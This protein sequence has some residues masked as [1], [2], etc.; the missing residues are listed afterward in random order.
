M[1]RLCRLYLDSLP[2]RK[3]YSN[4]HHQ[5][6]Q[7][8]CTQRACQKTY[9]EAPFY[10]PG[11]NQFRMSHSKFGNAHVITYNHGR[12]RNKANNS[13]PSPIS[14]RNTP[15][16]VLPIAI[17][18]AISER[19]GAYGTKRCLLTPKIHSPA[20]RAPPQSDCSPYPY[21]H[22]SPRTATVVQYRERHLPQTHCPC[23]VSA[24]FRAETSPIIRSVGSRL[25]AENNLRPIVGKLCLN[26]ILSQMI[27]EPRFLN[28][29][30]IGTESYRSIPHLLDDCQNLHYLT[31]YS[32]KTPAP[33]L[34]KHRQ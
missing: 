13:N 17:R 30:A 21:R 10:R 22:S 7:Q 24:L 23:P 12:Q 15:P 9:Q 18:K 20:G 26:H 33:F 11:G 31:A 8:P 16:R 5:C 2:C 27:K 1:Q 3:P 32:A 28:S 14:K 6:Y 25:H 19:R 29:I 34:R 4:H